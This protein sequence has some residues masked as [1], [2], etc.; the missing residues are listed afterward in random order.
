[1]LSEKRLILRKISVTNCQFQPK[2]GDKNHNL[3]KVSEMLEGVKTDLIVLPEFFSTGISHEAFKNFPEDENGGET[4]DFLKKLAVKLNANIICGSVIE[5]V[6][7]KSYNT[8]FVL[9]RKG[10]TVCKYRKIHLFNCFGGTEHKRIT[11]GENIVIAD[12]DIGKIGMA[13]CFDIRYPQHFAAL[14]QQGAE[15]FVCP[16]AWGFHSEFGKNM[17]WLTVWK[18]MNVARSNENITPL[19]SANQ[20]GSNGNG[21]TL[22]GNSMITDKTGKVLTNS[23]NKETINTVIIEV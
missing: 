5:R 9:N 14:K 18:S 6:S 11:A 7:G 19:I 17:D 4:I 13:I 16:T 21:F 23:E 15:L 1:M 3:N 20:T 2:C 10:E 8:S 22:I 12:L